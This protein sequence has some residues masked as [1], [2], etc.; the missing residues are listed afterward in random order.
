MNRAVKLDQDA[1]KALS[2]LKKARKTHNASQIFRE[3]LWHYHDFLFAHIAL[4]SA[5]NV[6]PTNN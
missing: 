6:Q 4:V 1:E 3:A 2:Q 5:K